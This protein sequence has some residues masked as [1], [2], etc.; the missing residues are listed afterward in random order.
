MRARARTHSHGR[1]RTR[2]QNARTPAKMRLHSR[3][4]PNFIAHGGEDMRRD[5][6]AMLPVGALAGWRWWV[7]YVHGGFAALRIT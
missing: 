4:L 3:R 5:K 1:T 7:A 2:R 6:S